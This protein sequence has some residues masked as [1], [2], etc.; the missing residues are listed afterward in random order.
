MKK[1]L[2]FGAG[3]LQKSIILRAKELGLFTVGI[4]PDSN[5][6][7]QSK[8]DKFEVVD[9]ND[10]EKT[11]NI[12][13]K[14]DIDGIVT[15]ATDKPLIMMSRIAEKYGFPF[16]TVNSIHKSTDKYLMKETFITHKIPCARGFRVQ[17]E[18]DIIN[19]FEYFTPPII[20]K[21]TDSSGSR[22]V[23]LCKTLNEAMESFEISS[24]Y[25]SHGDALIEEFVDGK[26]LSV[27]CLIYMGKLQII[28]YTD[29]IV[30]KP[31]FNV[32]M[33]HIQP[34][35]LSVYHKQRIEEILIDAVMALELDNCAIHAELKISE[36]GIKIIEIGARLGGD[37]ITS[38]LV[39]LSC[40]INMERILCEIA[41]GKE[42]YIVHSNNEFS[43]IKYIELQNGKLKEIHDLEE[44]NEIA[45]MFKFNLEGGS[46]IKPIRNS[47]ERYG[48]FI[49]QGKSLLDISKKSRAIS[50][51]LDKNIVIE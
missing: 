2:V 33:G 12:V 26:E 45:V 8:L 28:Q 48:Y 7:A 9:G 17:N 27:E 6:S 16:P 22:G 5:A 24:R 13:E 20:I 25:S 40:G 29:K 10:F 46:E 49:V 31:P 34:S 23:L 19:V 44:I 38:H 15:A 30:S 35:S 32:E 37:F 18:R 43:M 50:T 41:L 51:L 39:P 36:S 14:Y 47:L 21:P 4:D 42:P 3:E 11:C 1:L